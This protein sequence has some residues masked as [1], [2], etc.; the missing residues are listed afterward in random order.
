MR[1][2]R[3]YWWFYFEFKSLSRDETFRKRAMDAINKGKACGDDAWKGR[4]DPK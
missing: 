3:R 4:G 2:H 1:E